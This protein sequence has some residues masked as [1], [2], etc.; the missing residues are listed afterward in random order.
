VVHEWNVKTALQ[1]TELLPNGNLY[2]T[3]RDRSDINQAGLR[4]IDP[5]GNIVWSFH[6]RIDH[7]FHVMEN[8]HIMIHC[9]MDKMAPDIGPELKRYPIH[10]RGYTR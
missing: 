3:A 2:Y 10:N 9:I 1:L 5:E 7:D 8:G 6:C 4:E